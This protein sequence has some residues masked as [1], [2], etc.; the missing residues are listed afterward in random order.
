MLIDQAPCNRQAKSGASAASAHHWVE[1]RILQLGGDSWPIVFNIY[2]RRQTIALAVQGDLQRCTGT[3]GDSAA[4]LTQRLQGI[5]RDVQQYLLDLLRIVIQLWQAGV[6]V[7]QQG[8]VP[9]AL[10]ETSWQT[11]SAT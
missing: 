4:P 10:Q 7:T 2:A 6:I 1:Q 11:R 3:Q 8:D 5:P 9:R